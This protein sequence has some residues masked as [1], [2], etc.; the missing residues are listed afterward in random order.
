MSWSCYQVERFNY[1]QLTTHNSHRKP[2]PVSPFQFFH[3]V[4]AGLDH[5]KF[6]IDGPRHVEGNF[7]GLVQHEYAVPQVVFPDM[8]AE[9][10]A[11]KH[12]GE[13]PSILSADEQRFGTFAIAA[14]T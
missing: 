10:F 12:H 4:L 11:G 13:T 8:Y 5:V 3:F 2:N 14:A 6:Q 9:Q 7:A 1:S